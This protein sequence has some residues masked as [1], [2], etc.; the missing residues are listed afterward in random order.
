MLDFLNYFGNKVVG[1]YKTVE[2]N[3][4]NRSNS[5]YDS[6]L[7]LLEDTVK[8]ILMNED[9][10]Y[11]G[12]TCGEILR[13]PDVSNLLKHKVNINSDVYAKVGDYVKKINE[14]KHHN[15]KYVNVDTVVNYMRIYYEFVAPYIKYKGIEPSPFNESYFRGIYG[16]TLERS[17]E[18][19]NVSQKVNDFVSS[20]NTKFDE[21]ESRL[22]SL[23]AMSI[24]FSKRQ[25]E[26][27]VPQQTIQKQKSGAKSQQEIMHWFFRNSRKSWRWFGNKY[28]LD[29]SKKL[30]VFS[31]ILLLI[32]GFI[33]TLVT[34]ISVKL[35]TTFSLFENIWLIFGIL[36]LVYALRAKLKYES[37]EL[38]RNNNYKYRQDQYGLW[39]PGKEKF[40]YKL[41]R[42]LSII[43]V[44][45]NIIFIWMYSSNISW[46]ATI[47]EVL[48]L[49]AMIFSFFM[50]VSLF[51][52]YS[53]I[54]LEG[55][56]T[57]GIDVTLVWDP[58]MKK[59]LTEEEYKKEMPYLFKK[60]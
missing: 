43:S 19:D 52:Q 57:S 20:T 37:S 42:W 46:V 38:A 56:N 1:R 33:S 30:A 59:F 24:E 54:Y 35:Y 25:I 22:A 2:S 32:L 28:E 18:L 47:F 27:Q 12:R 26:P 53:I 10:G 48:F 44:V 29:K 13:E 6:Y 51:S 14:H 5:F 16:V 8:T 3:I 41:F 58:L 60:Y 36:L 21:H 7:D 50:N 11:E 39:N 4:R 49:G 34:S 23:E 17:K 40:V 45:G 15:E 9:V 55:K 31:H